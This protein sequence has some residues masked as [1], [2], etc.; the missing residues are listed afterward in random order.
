MPAVLPHLFNDSWVIDP[1]IQNSSAKNILGL[2]IQESEGTETEEEQG[3]LK[4][5][6]LNISYTHLSELIKIE[7][8]LK[9]RYF[10]LLILKIHPTVKELKRQINSLS[11]E[12]LGLS[13]DKEVAFKQLKQKIESHTTADMVKSHYFF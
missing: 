8:Q 13:A 5:V 10:E 6:L 2:P 9:R 4:D 12:R 11:F 1:R 7:D 3:H